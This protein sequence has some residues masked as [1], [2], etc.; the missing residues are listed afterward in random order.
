MEGE[1]ISPETRPQRQT[2]DTSLSY[3]VVN[4]ARINYEMFIAMNEFYGAELSFA[5]PTANT[6]TSIGIKVNEFIREFGRVLVGE[7]PLEE[8]QDQYVPDQAVLKAL[9]Q[10]TNP[11]PLQLREIIGEAGITNII[12]RQLARFLRDYN[13]NTS[14]EDQRV[15]IQRNNRRRQRQNAVYSQRIQWLSSLPN[16]NPTHP[17]DMCAVCHKEYSTAACV[18]FTRCDHIFHRDCLSTWFKTVY[19]CPLC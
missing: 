13:G 3:I 7:P 18:Q 9:M 10:T 6:L 5:N 17:T 1:P 14:V 4:N 16:A 8:N 15:Y 12:R 2:S 19:T 11:T